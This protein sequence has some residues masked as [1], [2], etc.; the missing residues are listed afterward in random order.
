MTLLWDADPGATERYDFAVG[1]ITRF[2]T[3]ATMV[4]AL[5]DNPTELLVLIGPDV[6][7]DAACQFAELCRVER[8]EL[9]V[10]LLRRRIDVA[11][12]GQ[13]LR[14]GIREVI[15]SDDVTGLADAAR[16]SRDLS[17]R[18][19][20]HAGEST[21]AKIS[22]VPDHPG[23][24]HVRDL[25]VWDALER[26]QA[27]REPAQARAQHH[28]DARALGAA[29][30]HECGSCSNGLRFTDAHLPSLTPATNDGH[31]GVLTMSPHGDI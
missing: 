28:A 30:G 1:A 6:D 19:H 24:R 27:I 14:A 9:G 23:A 13:A 15:T 21:Q 7:M 4:R 16:R 20:G 11:V 12:L 18:V 2:E 31:V 25:G 29:L 10:I 26:V 22:R 3:Q 8:P 17:T 5:E